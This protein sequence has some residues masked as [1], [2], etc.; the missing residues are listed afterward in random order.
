MATL[1]LMFGLTLFGSILL[2]LSFTM[3]SFLRASI[4][5]D[6]M[7]GIDRAVPRRRKRFNRR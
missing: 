5:P 3:S 2:V 1:S 6:L 7:V 4:R